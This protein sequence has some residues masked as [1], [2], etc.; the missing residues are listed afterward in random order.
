VKS[1]SLDVAAVCGPVFMLLLTNFVHASC[2]HDIQSRVHS[3]VSI[4]LTKLYDVSIVFTLL[5][6][7]TATSSN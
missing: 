6:D 5:H 2:R 3:I 7:G 1:K 4:M